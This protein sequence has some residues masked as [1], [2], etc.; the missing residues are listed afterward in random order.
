MNYS[1]LMH[2]QVYYTIITKHF[3]LR[4]YQS[5]NI[6]EDVSD[7]E[8]TV[9][10]KRLRLA[11]DYLQQLKAEGTHTHTLTPHS[12]LHMYMHDL[13]VCAFINEVVFNTVCFY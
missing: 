7:R 12:S 11:K 1:T 9:P 2:K 4:D 10:E 5:L 3:V 13:H 6:D 8:E